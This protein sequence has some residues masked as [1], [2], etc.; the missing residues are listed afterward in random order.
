MWK[1][2]DIVCFYVTSKNSTRNRGKLRKPSN[3]RV[4]IRK[5]YLRNTN[6]ERCNDV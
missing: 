4:G 5:V 6:V 3:K 1:E 2:A